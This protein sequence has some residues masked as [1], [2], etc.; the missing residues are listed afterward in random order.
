MHDS[1]LFLFISACH[2]YL[3]Y[4]NFLR[5]NGEQNCSIEVKSEIFGEPCSTTPKYLEVY[6]GCF[7]GILFLHMD[8]HTT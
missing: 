6:F 5:C 1:H 8:V 3:F 7:Q 4:I 2:F